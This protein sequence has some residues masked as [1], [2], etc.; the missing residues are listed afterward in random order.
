M[1]NDFS[2]CECGRTSG[3]DEAMGSPSVLY[4]HI[5]S[6]LFLYVLFLLFLGTFQWMLVAQAFN[7]HLY[8][9]ESYGNSSQLCILVEHLQ[10]PPLSPTSMTDSPPFQSH[11]F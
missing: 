2:D 9:D 5:S 11:L 6:L 1:L 7:L 3:V 8:R 4:A 10:L